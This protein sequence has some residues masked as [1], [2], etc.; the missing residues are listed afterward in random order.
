MTSIVGPLVKP[1]RLETRFDRT[2]LH[3]H[4]F[5]HPVLLV[6]LLLIA[7]AAAAV[8]THAVTLPI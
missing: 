8:A 1:N 2:A 4:A 7:A 5:R 3:S 6:V